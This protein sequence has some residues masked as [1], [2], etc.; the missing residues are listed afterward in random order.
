MVAI[1]EQT[2][3][4]VNQIGLHARP[5]SMFVQ[6]AARFQAA[7]QVSCAGRTADAKSILQVL[8]LG[9]ERGAVLQIR[10]EGEDAAA[11][12]SALGEL[13]ASRFGEPE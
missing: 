1:V 5:A 9:A 7:I 8:Q 13:I 6:T 2:Y 11:A 3:T 10:A 4:L 12:V